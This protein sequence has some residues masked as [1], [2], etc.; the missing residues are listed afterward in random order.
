[1]PAKLIKNVQEAIKSDG[2][3]TSEHIHMETADGTIELNGTVDSLT[4]LGIVQ[5]V[6]EAVPGVTTVVNRLNIEAEVEKGPCC[7]QM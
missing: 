1:M 4:E 3:I 6:V 2:R 5:E 7:P